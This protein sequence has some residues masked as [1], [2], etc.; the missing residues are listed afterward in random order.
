MALPRA[1]APQ[2]CSPTSADPT[3]MTLIP[4]A[5]ACPECGSYDVVYSCKPD[6]CFNHV[7]SKC[8]TTFEPVTTTTGA[9][10]GATGCLPPAPAPTRPPA[11][12]ARCRQTRLCAPRDPV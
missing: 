6:C 1:G 11:A 2:G 3:D 8:Y 5:I 4:L 7:C 12:C 9:L 10:T